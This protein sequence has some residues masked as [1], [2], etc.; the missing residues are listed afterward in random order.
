MKMSEPMQSKLPIVL[1]MAI[2]RKF[3]IKLISTNGTNISSIH[4]TAVGLNTLELMNSSKN[5][6]FEK[7]L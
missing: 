2:G 4:S 6:E 5:C 3:R 1:T 7:E